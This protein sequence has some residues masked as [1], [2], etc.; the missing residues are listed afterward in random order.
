MPCSVRRRLARSLSFRAGPRF[1]AGYMGDA[2]DPIHRTL[3]LET[4]PD[5]FRDPS[6]ENGTA[7]TTL[8]RTG[9]HVHTV[10]CLTILT[11]S[12]SVKEF[13]ESDRRDS[14]DGGSAL[15][16]AGATEGSRWQARRQIIIFKQFNIL[17]KGGCP[18]A[19]ARTFNWRVFR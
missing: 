12:P 16:P 18:G 9:C 1:V 10:D 3:C 11:R 17:R 5:K 19:Q 13:M 4:A 2:S 8:D 7:G 14:Q 6:R 15:P